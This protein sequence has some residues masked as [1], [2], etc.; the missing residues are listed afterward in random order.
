MK[1]RKKKVLDVGQVARRKARESGLAPAVTRVIVDKRKRP[2]K[3][4]KRSL[5]EDVNL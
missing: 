5:E 3:H 1:K 4:K 2:A